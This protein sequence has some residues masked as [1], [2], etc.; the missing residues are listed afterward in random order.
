MICSVANLTAQI[1]A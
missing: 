1:Q